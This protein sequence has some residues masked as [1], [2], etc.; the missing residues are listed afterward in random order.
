MV[1]VLAVSVLAVSPAHTGRPA[2]ATASGAMSFWE[3]AGRGLVTAT[4][5]NET[6][7]RGGHPVTS[8]VGIRLDNAANV[9]VNVSEPAVLMSPHPL[10]S[11]PPD[12]LRT[13]QDGIL[14]AQT[15]PAGGSL[16]Y[17]YGDDVL[18]GFLDHPAWWCS[19]EFQ[20][21]QANIRYRIGGETL[22]FALRPIVANEHYDGPNSNTQGDVWAYL[23]MHATVVVGKEPLWAQ[24]DGTAGGRIHVTIDATNLAVYTFDD[25]ITADVNVT[26][27]ALEDDVP[28]GW[29]V[30]EGSFSVPPDE[31]VGHPDGSHTLR[32]FVD[33]PAALAS[34]SDDPQY[35]S[36]YEPVIR[37]YTLVS[38]ALDAGRVELPRARSDIDGDGAPDANSA[39]PLIDV[40]PVGVPV[41]DAGGPYTGY[42]GSTILLNAS[43]STDPDGDSLQ[44]RWDFTGDGVYD[45][46]WS[47]NPTAA[48]R[49]TDDFSGV[50][51]VEV[52]D[53]THVA[54][55]K[56]GVTIANLPPEI[57]RFDAVAQA[58]FRIMMAGEKWHDLAF[59]I[60]SD[61]GV[62]ASLDLVRT[63][64]SPGAQAATTDVVTFSL[65]EH[66]SATLVYTPQDDP[67]NGRPAG[68]NPAWIGVVLPDGREVRISHNFNGQRPS[69][70]TWSET[71]LAAFFLHVG[72]T[73]R[74]SLHDAG[75]DDLTATWDFGDGRSATETFFN[76]GV[77]PDPPQSQGGV[78]PFDVS[79][80]IV[81][82]YAGAGPFTITL[83]VRD[84]DGGV[85]QATIVLSNA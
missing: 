17:S 13:T 82:P 78:A 46:A 71:D 59:T 77:S 38:P 83:T 6:Y 45:T 24:T 41:P 62:L 40:V 7:I 31:I 53:G 20:F 1:I 52:S 49:Y 42:E 60:N 23:R 61:S 19:E 14:T 65:R 37:S 28:A 27:G 34:S 21:T 76:N 16:R 18:Q 57:R 39:A 12:P 84:D 63:P 72:I 79:A 29:S 4:V 26:H 22:P 10:E 32:W 67:V 15:I 54:T 36:A 66:V 73:F 80:S 11:P 55:A 25:A 51:I 81:H 3:A 2:T 30:E 47:P 70:W 69:T 8:P 43:R 68:D 56:A 58:S 35:P 44:Y 74:T 33:L 50:A 64:G 48:A 5:V 75:S 9:P 85:A